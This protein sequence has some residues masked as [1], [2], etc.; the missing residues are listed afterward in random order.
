MLLADLKQPDRVPPKHTIE[1]MARSIA[2]HGLVNPILID[3]HKNIIN[4]VLRYYACMTLGKIE[5]ETEYN[6]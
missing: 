5:I 3:R 2:R 6:D 1:T 4:G